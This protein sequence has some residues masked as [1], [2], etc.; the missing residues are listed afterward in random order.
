MARR[1]RNWD[2]LES[3]LAKFGDVT[4][5]GAPTGKFATITNN[6]FHDSSSAGMVLAI[7]EPACPRGVFNLAT[8]ARLGLARLASSLIADAVA[9]AATAAACRLASRAGSRLHGSVE[10]GLTRRSL[11]PA[12]L[13]LL[14]AVGTCLVA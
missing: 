12:S 14:L 6:K 3:K 8:G 7:H 13:A 9:A 5:N 11:R 2:A 4:R 1:P 10:G